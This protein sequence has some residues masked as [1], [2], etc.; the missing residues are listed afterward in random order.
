MITQA[1]EKSKAN[2]KEICVVQ[3]F[4]SVDDVCCAYGKPVQGQGL[5]CS[6]CSQDGLYQG[7]VSGSAA[8]VR[9]KSEGDAYFLFFC[10]CPRGGGYSGGA[11]QQSEDLVR[12]EGFQHKKKKKINK[13]RKKKQGS[14]VLN[15][16]GLGVEAEN[17]TDSVWK[18]RRMKCGDEQETV[19]AARPGAVSVNHPPAAVGDCLG[20]C[21]LT[22]RRPCPTARRRQIPPPSP[23]SVLSRRRFA[24]PPVSADT[25]TWRR[26][27]TVYIRYIQLKHTYIKRKN[28]LKKSKKVIDNPGTP[29]YNQQ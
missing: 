22:P 29:G 15:A 1:G 6:G 10:V 7:I 8:A 4:G 19:L 25:S 16:V 11:E 24:P 9:I 20:E 17:V 21:H 28:F 3:R 23:P 2:T 27:L 12:N 5:Q 26:S 14:A 13:K 18:I